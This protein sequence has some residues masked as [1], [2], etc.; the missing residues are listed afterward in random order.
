MKN[1]TKKAMSDSLKTLLAR[2]PLNRITINDIVQNC[3]ISRMTFYYH[4]EDIY[5]LLKWTY[6]EDAR[7]AIGENTTLE[8]WQKGLESLLNLV[9]ENKANILN[10]YHSA[11][12]EQ[13]EL[14]LLQA[15]ENLLMPVVESQAEGMKISPEG[16][17]YVATFYA[18][19][20]MGATLEWVNKGMKK[21]PREVVAITAAIIQGDFKNALA[22]ISR[23]ERRSAEEG[24]T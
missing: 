19:A 22:N 15:A 10:V 2:K 13:I 16:K 8:T 21:S 3:G 18:Y 4:F 17:R 1:A 6:L 7:A 12:R 24:A 11:S 5:D 23:L 9:L 14:F 20:M